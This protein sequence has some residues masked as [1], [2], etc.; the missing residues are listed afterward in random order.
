MRAST[1]PSMLPRALVGVTQASTCWARML[2]WTM[3]TSGASSNAARHASTT[4]G[5]TS[6]STTDS[7]EF[8]CTTTMASPLVNVLI[9]SHR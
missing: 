5:L 6:T 7:S 3:R 4:D 1:P 8:L 9:P 2:P